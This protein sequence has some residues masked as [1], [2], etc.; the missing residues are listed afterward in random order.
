M[1]PELWELGTK[2]G[3]QLVRNFNWLCLQQTFLCEKEGTSQIEVE[4]S[5]AH[6]WFC[7]CA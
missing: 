5:L 3:I 4:K 6:Y 1:K 7:K 2:T